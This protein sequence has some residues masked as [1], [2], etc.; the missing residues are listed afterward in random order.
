MSDSAH[1]P[2]RF[3]VFGGTGQTGQHFIPAVLADGYQVRTLAR[4]PMK[5]RTTGPG[6]EVRP[7]SITELDSDDLDDL[8]TGIDFVI[9]M[10]GDTRLQRDEKIN[11]A[12]VKKLIPA[13]RRRGVTR[14]LYQA[15]GLS[16]PPG[17][18]LSPTLW[19]IRKT[20]ARGYNGQHEDNEAVMRFLADEADDIEWIVHRA[21]IGSD[22][23]SKGTLHRSAT[24]FSVA[25]FIDC[26]TYNYTTLTDPTAIHTCHLSTY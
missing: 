24:K 15:G 20:L 13:M 5:L 9:A 2:K 19:T 14:F 12:F 8:V 11:T 7:G 21:G 6:I 22:G 10:L 18:R 4:T 16:A 23:S 3:L 1:H 25:T 17:G 26:A